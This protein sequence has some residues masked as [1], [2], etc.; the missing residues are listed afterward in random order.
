MTDI[1]KN[2]RRDYG[3]KKF[4]LSYYG[5]QAANSF[6]FFKKASD[7]NWSQI[8]RLVF[9]CSG[10]ICRSPYGEFY[11]RKLGIDASSCGLHA[12]DGGAANERA[13]SVA[14]K[15]WTLSHAWQPCYPGRGPI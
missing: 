3:T 9:V 1:H 5:H 14:S 11:A 2:Y 6:G 7:V 8:T 4:L 15:H 12:D 13:I 10:N